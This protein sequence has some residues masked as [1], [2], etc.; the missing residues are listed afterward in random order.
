ML[1]EEVTFNDSEFIV[2][3]TDIEGK[4]AYGNSLF[5]KISGFHEKE[6]LGAPHNVL[7]HPDMPKAIFKLLWDRVKNGQEIFAYVKN[8]TKDKRFYWV[9]AHVTPSFDGAGKIIGFHSVRRKPTSH[10]LDV[11]VPLYQE[12]IHSERL[13][14]IH[15]SL[16]LLESKLQLKGIGYDEFIFSI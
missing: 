8:Q 12:L 2:S 4:I 5:I 3:K 15:S 11:V 13:N 9:F 1:G 6:L 7:R 10:A 14:G 16:K